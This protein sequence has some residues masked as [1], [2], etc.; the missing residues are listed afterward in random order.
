[1]ELGQLKTEQGGNGLLRIHLWC[2]DD[3]P[4]FKVM[5]KNR[6]KPLAL[7]FRSGSKHLVRM[8]VS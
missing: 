8:T 6:I 4:R 1:M 5:G 3:L 2:P 7:C